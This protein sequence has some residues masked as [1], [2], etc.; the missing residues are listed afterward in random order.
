MTTI[1]VLCLDAGK[2]PAD[3]VAFIKAKAAV[4]LQ[5]ALSLE[6][7]AGYWASAAESHVDVFSD[8]FAFRL[9]LFCN[10]RASLSL[11]GHRAL[12]HLSDRASAPSCS[13]SETVLQG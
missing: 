5:L 1:I 2:W 3:E 9:Y 13:M 4:G 7:S 12:T 11:P 8:G 6:S 10:R